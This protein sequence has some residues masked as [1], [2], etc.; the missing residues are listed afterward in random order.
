MARGGFEPPKPLGRQIYSLLRLTAPQPR[1]SQAGMCPFRTRRHPLHTRPVVGLFLLKR[2]LEL[3]LEQLVYCLDGAELMHFAFV[4]TGAGEGI[5]TPDPLITNQLLYRTEL[6][7][8]SKF[9]ILAQTMLAD[10]GTLLT[11]AVSCL[12]KNKP[13]ADFIPAKPAV[14]F[15]VA[16]QSAARSLGFFPFRPTGFGLPC[17]LRQAVGGPP[18]RERCPWQPRR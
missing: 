8:P 4:A 10:N 16:S 6:R 9:F 13:L 11:S 1:P 18:Q 14:S 17:P 15:W 12:H 7:Q 3:H 5:R 2:S